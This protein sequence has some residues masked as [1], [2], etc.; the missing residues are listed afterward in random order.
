M[1]GRLNTEKMQD[2]EFINRFCSFN[3]LS[4]DTYR[5]D[6]DDW[7]ARGLLHLSRMS[8]VDQDALSRKFR[9][10]LSNNR[11]VFD[12]YAFRKHRQPGQPRSILNASLFDV[13]M[14]EM[15]RLD[16]ERVAA[17][18]EALREAFYARMADPIFTRSIT[19]GTNSTREVRAR[20]RI[21]CE[22][23]REVFDA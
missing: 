20:F 11:L 23:F 14:F 5:G 22:M 4:I 12:R 21:A 6:M 13:M 16:P 18:S 15:C 3:L 19:Y 10:G 9:R 7:L 8:E 17:N 1:Q 2:R